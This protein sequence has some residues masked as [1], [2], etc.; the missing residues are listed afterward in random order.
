VEMDLKFLLEHL[1]WKRDT[2]RL[3]L[4]TLGLQE[5]H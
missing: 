3:F 2:S 5:Q 1:I 4:I